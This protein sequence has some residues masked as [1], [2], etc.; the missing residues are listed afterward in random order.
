M[1]QKIGK[2]ARIKF[3]TIVNCKSVKIA[4]GVVIGPFCYVKSDDL[5]IGDNSS[6]KSL[7]VVSTRIIKIGKYVQ[8]APLSIISS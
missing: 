5:V 2:G 8:I 3:G 6:I 1:G 7:R 4:N